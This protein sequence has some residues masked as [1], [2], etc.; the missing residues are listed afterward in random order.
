MATHDEPP[1]TYSDALVVLE[2]IAAKV[3]R[4]DEALEALK[5]Q[6]RAATGDALRLGQ[7]EDVPAF[8]TEVQKRS[9]FSPPIVR[10]I[11]EAEG[12]PANDN[13]RRFPRKSE[14]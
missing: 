14:S 13:Y 6:A 3:R 11:G 10:A 7:A 1:A 8:R 2:K 4:A 5:A 9:P 12:V